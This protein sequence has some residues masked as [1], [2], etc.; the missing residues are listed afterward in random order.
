MKVP[1]EIAQGAIRFSLGYDIS[2]EDIEKTVET[3]K[4]VVSK[5]RDMSPLYEDMLDELKENRG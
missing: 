2:L 1:I 5:I 4:K 3:L